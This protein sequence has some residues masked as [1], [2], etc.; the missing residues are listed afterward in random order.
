M[1]NINHYLVLGAERDA[2]L[3]EIEAA[4]TRATVQLHT[5]LAGRGAGG[6]QTARI[7]EAYTVL[8]DPA[9]RAEYD[10]LLG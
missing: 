8:R 10:S 9:R 6:K 2:S 5:Q 3:Q 1:D 4:F 7:E